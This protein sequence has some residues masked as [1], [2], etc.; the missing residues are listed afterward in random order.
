MNSFNIIL[1]NIMHDVILNNIF[2]SKVNN[3]EPMLIIITA[4]IALTGF[5]WNNW[6]VSAQDGHSGLLSGDSM[7]L[8]KTLKKTEDL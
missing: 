7:T 6:F 8:G 5:S 3:I 1:N 4:I 2:T